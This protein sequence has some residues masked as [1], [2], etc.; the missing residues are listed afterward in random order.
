MSKHNKFNLA[1]ILKYALEVNIISSKIY[2]QIYLMC[3]SKKGREILK[4][5]DAN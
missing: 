2:F 1:N 4:I 3:V 5:N